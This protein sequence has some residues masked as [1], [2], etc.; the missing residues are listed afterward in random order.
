MQKLPCAVTAPSSISFAFFRFLPQFTSCLCFHQ[1]Q[2]PR[3]E[4]MKDNNTLFGSHACYNS[5]M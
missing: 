2:W 1:S 5:I 3:K 4:T